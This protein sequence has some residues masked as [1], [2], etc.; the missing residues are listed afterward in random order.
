MQQLQTTL[1]SSK[2][3]LSQKIGALKKEITRMKAKVFPSATLTTKALPF[4]VVSIESWN[5]SPY[6]EITQRHN[7]TMI[8]YTGLYQVLSGWKVIDISAPKQTVTFIN[9][10]EQV[11]HV[12]IKPF[13]GKN[14]E[15]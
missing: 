11:V 5:G 1:R 8:T 15:S 4:K 13:G 12:Q 14:H 2:S 6:A 3:S 10:Q 9:A 7:S